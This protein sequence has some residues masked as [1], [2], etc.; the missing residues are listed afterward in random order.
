MNE[1]T[2]SKIVNVAMPVDVSRLYGKKDGSTVLMWDPNKGCYYETSVAG[3]VAKAVS[4]VEERL[5][6]ME[7]ANSDALRELGAKEAQMEETMN[8]FMADVKKTN[9]I[10][11]E[12]VEKGK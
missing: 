10:I 3:I 2:K 7:K 1:R 4:K 6:E 11:I 8:S 9:Q 5:S 12:L